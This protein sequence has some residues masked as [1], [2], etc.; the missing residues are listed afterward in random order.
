M[1]LFVELIATHLDREVYRPLWTLSDRDRVIDGV[2]YKS[3]QRLYLECND[4]T[5][6]K[7]AN[8]YFG[9]WEHWQRIA[10]NKDVTEYVNLWRT[11]LKAKIESEAFE[12]ARRIAA[13]GEGA[14]ALQAAKWLH[15][16]VQP[17]ATKGRPA[18]KD[19]EQAAKKL[20][21]ETKESKEDQAR[22]GIQTEELSEVEKAILEDI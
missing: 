15:A 16:A 20:V 17:K 12:A 8:K 19:I 10:S 7:F 4:P 21:Q 18:K 22:I 9:S 3:L 13:E 5:E 1:S 11:E 2:R 6:Y 14:V